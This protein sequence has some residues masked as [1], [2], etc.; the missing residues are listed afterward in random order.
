MKNK[1][2]CRHINRVSIEHKGKIIG[3][4][5]I[6]QCENDS[7]PGMVF[8]SEHATRDAMGYWIEQLAEKINKL[9]GTI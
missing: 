3:S 1:N 4:P 5:S 2:K 7:L 6:G 9:G 8:C